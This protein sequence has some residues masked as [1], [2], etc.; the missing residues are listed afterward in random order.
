MI[1][2]SLASK[3]FYQCQTTSSYSRFLGRR[4]VISEA[5]AKPTPWDSHYGVHVH[6]L[7]LCSLLVVEKQEEQKANHRDGLC[8][9]AFLAGF[10]H[11]PSLKKQDAKLEREA[12]GFGPWRAWRPKP[13][14]WRVSYNCLSPYE[15]WQIKASIINTFLNTI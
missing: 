12:S 6:V 1:F 5:I 10:H 7:G 15:G 9:H 2:T 8:I 11:K 4:R 14:D 3:Y 13:R